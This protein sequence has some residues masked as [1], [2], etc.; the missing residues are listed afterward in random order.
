MNTATPTHRLATQRPVE[1]QPR[2][3]QQTR[4]RMLL[5][6]GALSPALAACQAGAQSGAGGGQQRSKAPFTLEVI[7][8]FPS[9]ESEQWFT[10]QFIPQYQARAGSHVS[11]NLTWVAFDKMEDHFGVNKVAGTLQDV[12]RTGA[13]PWVWIYAEKQVGLPIDDRVK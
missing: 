6:C 12:I 8:T 9:P 1:T 7:Q 13:G 10:E 4:R 3:R 11:V 5:A 2:M